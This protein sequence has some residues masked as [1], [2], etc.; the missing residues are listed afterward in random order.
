MHCLW[1]MFRHQRLAVLPFVLVTALGACDQPRAK[2]PDDCGPEDDIERG[3][4]TAGEGAETGIVHAA[5]KSLDAVGESTASFF[6]DGSEAAGETWDAE[7]DE[8]K[9][10]TRQ[11]AQDT[12]ETARDD[13]CGE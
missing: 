3:L 6:N 11:A 13:H 1:V 7:V 4:D 5:G 2:S 12:E 8:M 9:R 10:D